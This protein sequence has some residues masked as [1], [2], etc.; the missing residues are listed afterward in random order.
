MSDQ[1]IPPASALNSAPLADSE[2]PR[3]GRPPLTADQ[4][5]ARAA[6]KKQKKSDKLLN[7]PLKQAPRIPVPEFKK[8]DY[9]PMYPTLKKLIKDYGLHNVKAALE[10]L[11]DE[12][13]T[14]SIG[15]TEDE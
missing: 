6:I 10:I 13:T 14:L 3:R 15:K 12:I 8:I 5:I 4:K 2:K 11:D 9:E 7:S 1:N